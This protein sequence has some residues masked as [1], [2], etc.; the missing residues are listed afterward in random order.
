[1]KYKLDIK[2]IDRTNI[3]HIYQ[4]PLY[5]NFMNDEINTL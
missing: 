4:F 2:Y 1:M 5:S 3:D